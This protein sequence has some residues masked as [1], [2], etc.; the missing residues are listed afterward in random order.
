VLSNLLLVLCDGLL[1]RLGSALLEG[2]EVA[3]TLE[4]HGSDQALNL[5][6]L[7]V[8]LSTRSGDLSL[9][10]KCPDVVLL[11]EVEEL[12]NP[13]GSLGSKSF[14]KSDVGQTRELLLALLD[15]DGG[16]D[17]NVVSDDAS[18]DRLS[19]SLSS[20]AGTVARVAL[21][22]EEFGSVL[23]KHGRKV[24]DTQANSLAQAPF[25]KKRIADA[26]G[27]R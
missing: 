16:E 25:I 11:V 4:S 10:H 8:C 27:G 5:G 18:S 21:A 15:N 13:S 22:E 19:L 1:L 26:S 2:L 7:G 17:L 3:F 12:S 24:W 6:R 20:S 14:G 9:D 23:I